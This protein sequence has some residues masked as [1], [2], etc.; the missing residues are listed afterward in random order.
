MIPLAIR[1]I[2][3][4]AGRAK[5]SGIGLI[6]PSKLKELYMRGETLPHSA[7][8]TG[9]QARVGRKQMFGPGVQGRDVTTNRGT[10]SAYA[11]SAMGRGVPIIRSKEITP[12][13]REIATYD[14]YGHSFLRYK[15]YPNHI[16]IDPTRGQFPVDRGK[17]IMENIK[18]ALRYRSDDYYSSLKYNTAKELAQRNPRYFP[19]LQRFYG[20]K[21]LIRKIKDPKQREILRKLF[22]GDIS[23]LRQGGRV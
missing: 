2:I 7:G 20:I 9:M 15:S 13:F 23:N 18:S 16:K 4:A 21:D 17:S 6:K 19:E 11:Q 12:S 10:A 5:P 1:G 3:A 14:P 22:F 8:L